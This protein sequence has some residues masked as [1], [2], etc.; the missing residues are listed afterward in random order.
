[1][2]RYT[3]YE[4]T[5]VEICIYRVEVTKPRDEWRS[6][7]WWRTPLIPALGRQKQADF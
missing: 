6:Q 7:A 5:A 3:T 1:M 4:T 2:L